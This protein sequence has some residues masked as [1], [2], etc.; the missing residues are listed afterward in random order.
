MKAAASA[1][2]KSSCSSSNIRLLIAQCFPDR[3]FIVAS[4]VCKQA[5][6]E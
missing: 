6:Q 2:P 1:F 5:I 3:L 4:I